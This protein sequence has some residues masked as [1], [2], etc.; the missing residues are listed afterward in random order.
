MGA[1]HLDRAEPGSGGMMKDDQL[2][3]RTKFLIEK[4]QEYRTS[5]ETLSFCHVLMPY[6]WVDAPSTSTISSE[7]DLLEF[8]YSVL[9]DDA[10]WDLANSVNNLINL[11]RKLEAWEI[12]VGELA[13]KQKALLLDEF[14]GDVATI[15]M[16]LPYA[17]KSRFFFHCAHLSHQAN[18]L[19]AGD[20]WKDDFLTLSEDKGIKESVASDVARGWHSWKKIIRHLNRTDSNDFKIATDDFRN[21]YTHRFAPG[22]EVGMTQ[23]V[24]R[25]STSGGGVIP[26]YKL[27]SSAPIRLSVL[28]PALKQQCKHFGKS[29]TCFQ[30]LVTE[31]LEEF[32]SRRATSL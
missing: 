15:A 6:R 4:Y 14:V 17:I 31:Q 19:S 26:D 12:V 21:K 28:V 11:T 7:L 9:A 25:M 23:P 27:G 22:I 30:N 8:N 20:A 10:A 16:L 5:Y 1:A 2:D 18:A 29:H 13:V 32:V 3:S 24:K